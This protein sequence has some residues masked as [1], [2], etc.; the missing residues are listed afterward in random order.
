MTG[1]V[2]GHI[3]SN[4][5]GYIALFFA[6]SLG[7]AWAAT[8][9]SKN[10]V[11]SKHIGKGQVKSADLGANSVTSPKVADA[12]L[13][14]QDFAPGQ[15][16]AGPQ[17]ERG[18][19]GPPGETGAAGSPDTP[20]QVLDKVKQVDGSGSG[21]SADQVD[22][23]DAGAFAPASA[24]SSIG[25]ISVDDPLTVGPTDAT[26]FTVGPLTLTRR[27]VD[28]DPGFQRSAE[29]IL[30]SS[31]DGGHYTLVGNEPNTANAVGSE[32]A[33]S[34]VGDPPRLIDVGPTGAADLQQ[35]IVTLLPPGGGQ[36]RTAI[37]YGGANVL[38]TDCVFGYT[39]FSP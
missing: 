22:G 24:A 38:G 28:L 34:T 6:M 17:G 19:V 21:L 29:I 36:V 16:P 32:D 12:S 39:L 37:L 8:E 4:A 30:T 15:L 35:S 10:E 2:G 5:V 31:Q 14:E 7:T 13:L 27:C 1:E 18:P 23:L 11:R 9:L 26:L 20:Q 33:V 3:R 25:P